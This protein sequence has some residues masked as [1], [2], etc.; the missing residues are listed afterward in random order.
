MESIV[1]QKSTKSGI[2]PTISNTY[3]ETH[4]QVGTRV[5]KNR[6]I[7]GLPAAFMLKIG[8]ALNQICDAN[9]IVIAQ[10]K[11]L[12]LLIKPIIKETPDTATVLGN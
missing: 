3:F 8:N 11:A 10:V 4:F 9:Q 5:K 12:K 6:T 2:G 1:Q 7:S